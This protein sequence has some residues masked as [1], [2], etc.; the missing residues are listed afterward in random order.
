MNNWFELLLKNPK[1]SK[2]IDNENACG[3]VF[4]ENIILRISIFVIVL[5]F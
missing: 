3:A 2:K 1:R 4:L 5:Y